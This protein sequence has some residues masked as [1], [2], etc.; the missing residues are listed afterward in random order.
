MAS[1]TATGTASDKVVVSQLCLIP[2][3]LVAVSRT[4]SRPGLLKCMLQH[5]CSWHPFPQRHQPCRAFVLY[6]RNQHC[7]GVQLPQHG[8]TGIIF[9]GESSSPWDPSP[10]PIWIATLRASPW[11]AGSVQLS[12]GVGWRWTPPLVPKQMGHHPSVYGKQWWLYLHQTLSSHFKNEEFKSSRIQSL[13]N[14]VVWPALPTRLS[15][16]HH[17]PHE[18]PPAHTVSPISDGNVLALKKKIFETQICVFYSYW[19]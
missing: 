15:T 3:V 14:H 12:C 7:K 4:L 2:K 8:A 1:L 17:W 6:P 16:L 9:P 18:S 13:K 11:L 10:G 5:Q 19:K